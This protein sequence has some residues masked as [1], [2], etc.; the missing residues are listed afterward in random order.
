[1][2]FVLE[3]NDTKVLLKDAWTL[4][5]I[6][7]YIILYT[8]N[9]MLLRYYCNYLFQLPLSGYFQRNNIKRMLLTWYPEYPLSPA[10]NWHT[11][12]FLLFTQFFHL[13]FEKVY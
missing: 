8:D 6:F 4:K 3:I 7:I 2:F 10:L 5:N 13:F 1:M 9:L 12:G 11:K